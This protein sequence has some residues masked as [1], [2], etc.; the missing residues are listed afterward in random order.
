MFANVA[1]SLAGVIPKTSFA[2]SFQVINNTRFVFKHPNL[3][4]I[5]QDQDRR[6]HVSMHEHPKSFRDNSILKETPEFS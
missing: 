5:P 3:Q 4:Q 2:V 6:S 1:A